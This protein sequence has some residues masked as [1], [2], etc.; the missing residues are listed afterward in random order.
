[1]NN[2]LKI[3]ARIILGIVLLVFGM[4]KLIPFLPPQN[5]SDEVMH[6]FG[7][8]LALKFVLPTVAIIEVIVGLSLLLNR[9]T[10]L[11]LVILMPISYSIV[12]FHLTVD[13][14]GIMP[15]AFVALLNIGLLVI[16]RATYRKVLVMLLY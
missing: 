6:A 13:P 2:K 14:A 9:F 12:A 11:A 10:S 16:D 4:N 5:M 1:M 7:A 15:A 3:T 8:L